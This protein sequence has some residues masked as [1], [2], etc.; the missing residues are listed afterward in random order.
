MKIYILHSID[1]YICKLIRMYVLLHLGQYL[2]SYRNLLLKGQCE[3][4]SDIGVIE[5]MKGSHK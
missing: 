2:E 4:D 1:T 3:F 5:T